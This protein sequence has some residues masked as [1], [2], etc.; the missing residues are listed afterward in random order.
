MKEVGERLK[1]SGRGMKEVGERNE[2]DRGKK[3]NGFGRGL[4][5]FGDRN[6]RGQRE[7]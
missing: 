3:Q 6:E 5:E 2:K 7:E 4:K 1:W